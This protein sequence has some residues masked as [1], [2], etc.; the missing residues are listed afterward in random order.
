FALRYGFFQGPGEARDGRYRVEPGAVATLFD[1]SPGAD[2]RHVTAELRL[3]RDALRMEPTLIDM[4]PALSGDTK[5]LA[6]GLGDNAYCR[7][8]PGERLVSLLSAD[9]PSLQRVLATD[10]LFVR[11]LSVE[12][13]E[14]PS[15][16]T[17]IMRNPHDMQGWRALLFCGPRMKTFLQDRLPILKDREMVFNLAKK[18][19]PEFLS[20][21]DPSLLNSVQFA[22]E[23]FREHRL[24]V[25]PYAS[26]R[27][28][29]FTEGGYAAFMA[30]DEAVVLRELAQEGAL[31]QLAPAPQQDSPRAVRV[32][33]GNDE[34]AINHASPAIQRLLYTFAGRQWDRTWGDDLAGYGIAVL[35]GATV[36]AREIMAFVLDQIEAYR[37]ALEGDPSLTPKT[38]WEG[39]REPAFMRDVTVVAL[40][41]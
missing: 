14:D 20:W 32:A 39:V 31:L 28:R 15:L 27:V 33:I 30:C 41:K 23:G 11:H 4:A 38:F 37:R 26:A 34:A 12:K 29:Q 18:A 2:P 24:N 1:L 35:N 36:T 8:R 7:A 40:P 22:F 19:D 13:R 17:A 16:I 9:A 3:M 25:L 10:P 21:A 5:A 6:Q